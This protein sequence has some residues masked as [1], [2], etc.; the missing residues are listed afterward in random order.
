MTVTVTNIICSWLE[1]AQYDR[2]YVTYVNYSAVLTSAVAIPL[3]CQWRLST[4]LL[5]FTFS[6]KSSD[7]YSMVPC[8]YLTNTVHISMFLAI[9]EVHGYLNYI[10]CSNLKCKGTCAPNQNLILYVVVPFWLSCLRVRLGFAPQ[11]NTGILQGRTDPGEQSWS[12]S[13]TPV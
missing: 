8:S 10:W 12:L 3:N 9:M 7:I 2:S 5:L 1:P 6:S 13:E 11:L 4:S